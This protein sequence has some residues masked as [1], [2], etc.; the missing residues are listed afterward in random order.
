M[1]PKEFIEKALYG[2]LEP[3]NTLLHDELMQ[4]YIKAKYIKIERELYRTKWFDY[5]YLDPVQATMLYAAYYEPIYAEQ[6]QRHATTEEAQYRKPITLEKLMREIVKPEPTPV[7]KSN[8]SSLFRGRAVADALGMPYDFFLRTSFEVRMRAWQNSRLPRPQQLYN[9]NFIP[10]V[11]E[12]WEKHKD[13]VR[14]HAKHPAY[15]AGH[16]EGTAFQNDYREFLLEQGHRQT[17]TDS[18]MWRYAEEGLL[19]EEQVEKFIQ[20]RRER[21]RNPSV[22]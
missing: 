13:Q 1:E 19:S 7:A 3:A 21:I 14:L 16:F 9:E 10:R 20:V 5:R 17:I 8:F 15:Q 11:I 4:R 22:D 12:E 6:V 2:Q 18:T